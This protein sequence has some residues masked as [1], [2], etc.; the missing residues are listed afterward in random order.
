M[1]L[2]HSYTGTF[3]PTVVLL[4]HEEI[5]LVE[6]I[7]VSAILLFII[8]KG[9]EKAYHSYAALMFEYLHCNLLI[10]KH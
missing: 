6:A 8:F 5:Q 3:L 4:L 1:H 2:H 9:L 10:N 7:G